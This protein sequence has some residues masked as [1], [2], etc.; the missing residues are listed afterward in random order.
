M[1]KILSWVSVQ[2]LF[3]SGGQVFLKLVMKKVGKFEWS[4]AYLKSLWSDWSFLL[5]FLACG[6]CFGVAA[7]LWLWILKK[8]PFNQAYPL[9]SLSFI[10]G[11]LAAWLVIGESIPYWRWIGLIL[12]VFGCF[13]IAK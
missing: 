5:L 13:L 7:V 4:W 2:T 9:T 3:L 11:M 1:W 12:V 6:I 10:F 8:F